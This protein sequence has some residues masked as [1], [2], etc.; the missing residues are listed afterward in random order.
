MTW[1]QQTYVEHLNVVED[2]VVVSK[3]IAGNDVDTGILLDLPV[4][5]TE[6]L[7]L[8]QEVSLGEVAGP[9]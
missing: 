9:V 7:G 6:T 5:T 4:L 3:V 8:G 1:S 2:V